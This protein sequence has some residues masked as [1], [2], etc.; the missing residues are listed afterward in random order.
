MI[1]GRY[2]PEGGFTSNG[3]VTWNAGIY[4]NIADFNLDGQIGITD[5]AEF[6]SSW[7]WRATL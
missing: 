2:I 4:F 6:A 1:G 3:Q 7:L 5:L